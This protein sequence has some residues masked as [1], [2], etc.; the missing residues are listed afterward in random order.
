MSKRPSPE[1]VDPANLPELARAVIAA[2]RFP[3]LATLDGDQPR[4]RPV[5]PVK[6]DGF[7]VYVANL[8]RYHK[9]EELEANPKCELVYLSSDHDQVRI[10]GVAEVVRERA[11]LDEI[12]RTNPLLRAY[13]GTPDNP[14]LIVY[15]IRPSRVR[16]MREWALDYHEVPLEAGEDTSGEEMAEIP[17]GDGPAAAGAQP[18]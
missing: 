18:G 4:V 8:R 9:T 6:T 2:D 15:R 14:E 16:F 12:W 7:T 11:V 5:S 17:G 3:R 10:T 1:P 13:L